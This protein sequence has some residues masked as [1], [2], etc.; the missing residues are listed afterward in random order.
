LLLA[1]WLLT[2]TLLAA[3]PGSRP[4][5]PSGYTTSGDRINGRT[6]ERSDK[7]N[8]KTLDTLP[9]ELSP[10]LKTLTMTRNIPGRSKPKILLFDRE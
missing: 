4:D 6:I 2:G 5:V 10:D 9:I 1:I 8:G 3:D 7:L